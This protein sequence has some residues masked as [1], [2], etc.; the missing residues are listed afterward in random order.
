ML[1]KGN[2]SDIARAEPLGGDALWHVQ[3]ADIPYPPYFRRK[4]V[5]DRVLVSLLLVPGL[6]MIGLL[7]LLIRLTSRGPGIY[8]QI[9]VGQG[10]RNFAIYKIRTMR[11]DARVPR[12]IFIGRLICRLRL[13]KLPE[14]LSSGELKAAICG[15]NLS[16]RDFWCLFSLKLLRLTSG[17]RLV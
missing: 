17:C 9:R 12:E 5:L 2:L 13:D 11:H 6:P 1:R 4:A 7:I 15:R 3:I 8:R 16:S 14:L 10:G